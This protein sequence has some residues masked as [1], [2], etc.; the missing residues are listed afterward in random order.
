MRSSERINVDT[1]IPEKINGFITTVAAPMIDHLIKE[2]TDAMKETSPVLTAF[3][4]FNPNSL[5]KSTEKHKQDLEVLCQHYGQVLIDDYE[6][7]TVTA[8]PIVNNVEADSELY[9]FAQEFE[10]IN[11]SLSEEVKL[12]A[13]KLLLSGKIKSDEVSSY[14]IN[15]AP[16]L[17][18][19]YKRFAA[20][21]SLTTYP[22]LAHLFRIC[23][24]IPPSTLPT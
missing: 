7:V 23:L 9:D 2:I 15:N 18:D 24:L 20:E 19:I 6:N 12:N 8:E 13:N 21:G 10:S 1:D 22:N 3:D 16:T 4:L 11:E 5:N 14:L 17:E